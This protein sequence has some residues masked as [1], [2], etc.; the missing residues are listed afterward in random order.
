MTTLAWQ[1]PLDCRRA[2]ARHIPLSGLR[3][4]RRFWSVLLV[5]T[6]I[7]GCARARSSV[8]VT[9]YG[10]NMAYELSDHTQTTTTFTTDDSLGNLRTDRIAAR[11]NVVGSFVGISNY[12]PSA[13]IPI[14][15]P[16][17][18]IAANLFHEIFY[19]AYAR[20]LNLKIHTLPWEDKLTQGTLDAEP[21]YHFQNGT[22]PEPVI[23]SLRVLSDLRLE[24]GPLADA[25][26]ATLARFDGTWGS[27]RA[28]SKTPGPTTIFGT[29]EPITKDRVLRELN[30]TLSIARIAL[31]APPPVDY[32]FYIAAHGLLDSTGTAYVLPADANSETRENWIRYTDILGPIYAF[33]REGGARVQCLVVFDACQ[34]GSTTA[35]TLPASPANVAVVRSAAAGEYA[36]HWGTTYREGRNINVRSR[37]LSL[38]LPASGSGHVEITQDTSMSVFPI[39]AA[40]ALTRIV[41]LSDAHPERDKSI[42]LQ[43]WMM[44]TTKYAEAFLKDIP[45][46]GDKRA[47]QTISVTTQDDSDTDVI[48]FDIADP[49]EQE[50]GQ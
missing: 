12:G 40:F 47:Q 13:N 35:T 23:P 26:A 49:A 19:R 8:T 29:G 11:T 16:A 5:V 30:D 21:G 10:D 28:P 20:A 31:D 41:Q 34:R 2:F 14:A 22:Q 37:F 33:A 1:G 4:S 46:Y 9:G 50:D 43:D 7:C 3:R 17:H 48:I 42:G 6:S 45:T 27:V 36:W 39:A 24:A 15:T 38:P 25:T 32:I 44:M 18:A